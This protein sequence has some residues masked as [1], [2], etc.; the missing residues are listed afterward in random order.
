MP[1]PVASGDQVDLEVQAKQ[2]VGEQRLQLICFEVATG[3]ARPRTGGSMSYGRTIR[4]Y[5]A[6]GSPTGIRHAELVNWTGQG[7]VC[8]RARIGELAAWDESKRPGVYILFGENPSGTNL[9]AYIG[10]AENVLDRM[11]D[12]IKKKDFWDRVVLFTSKDANLTKGHVKYLESRFVQIAGEAGR[13]AL[14]NANKPPQPALPRPDRDAMEEFIEAARI[15]LG[16]LGF[17][18]LQVLPK[19]AGP[20]VEV[21]GQAGP[22]AAIR[23]FFKVPKAGV[24]AQGAST[25]EG[26][27]VFAGSKGDAKV[28]D[29]LTTGWKERREQMIADGT[30]IVEG[31]TVRFAKDVLLPSPSAAAAVV[32]G[33][34]RNG[35]WVWKDAKGK[36]LKTYEEE[37]AGATLSDAPADAG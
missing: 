9:L 17:P 2:V 32:C 26:F 36:A 12:H 3:Q 23:F 10:E 16:A 4:I 34:N 33:G 30:I 20:A 31:A 19:K 6:D 15:L 27:V 25:D 14:E 13:V 37:L 8:P 28:Q 24:A 1:D 18:I 7:I 22:L 11:Q 29:Y 5:L 21:A 35:R